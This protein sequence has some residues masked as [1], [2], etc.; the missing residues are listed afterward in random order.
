MV[1][2]ESSSAAS[3]PTPPTPPTL[4][5]HI[6]CTHLV[7]SSQWVGVGGT[8]AGMGINVWSMNDGTTRPLEVP[9]VRLPRVR[10]TVFRLLLAVAVCAIVTYVVA[11]RPKDR[12]GEHYR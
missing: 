2:Q 9:A 1:A 5:M 10:F 11:E 7:N 4:L 6:K 8:G 3:P 12:A